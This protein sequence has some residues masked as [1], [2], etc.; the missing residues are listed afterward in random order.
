VPVALLVLVA[1]VV[2]GVSIMILTENRAASDHS[3][4]SSA[5]G[6]RHVVA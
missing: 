3:A 4:S 5:S 1:A 6:A 2:T